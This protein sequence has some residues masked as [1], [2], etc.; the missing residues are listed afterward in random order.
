MTYSIKITGSGTR[1]EIAKALL[2]ITNA[3]NP[4]TCNPDFSGTLTD[5]DG[6]EWEDCTLMTEINMD[7]SLSIERPLSLKHNFYL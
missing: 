5:I 7:K 1:E 3:V 4:A 2:L 6:A